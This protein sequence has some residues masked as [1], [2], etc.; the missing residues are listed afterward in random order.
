LNYF[1]DR[2]VATPD[3]VNKGL[4]DFFKGLKRED[5][6]LRQ[7]GERKAK[8][9]KEHMTF[10]LYEWLCRAFLKDGNTFA[11]L[12]LT[13]CWNL[14]CR[15]NNAAGIHFTHMAWLGDCLGIFLPKTKTDQEGEKQKERIHV[16]ANPLKAEIDPLAALGVWLMVNGQ[17]DGLKLFPGGSCPSPEDR[18]HSLFRQPG[19][20]ILQ[21]PLKDLED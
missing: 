11:W 14:M 10:E 7:N 19:E 18:A 6:A 2:G 5:T 17:W 1:K 9:G 21:P 13:L 12:Y 3:W 20:S 4:K 8:E 16:F 15:T